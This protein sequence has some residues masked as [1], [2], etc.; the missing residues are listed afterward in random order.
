MQQ[1]SL[2][3]CGCQVNKSFDGHLIFTLSMIGHSKIGL[4]I[5]FKGLPVSCTVGL[6]SLE[7]HKLFSF[8]APL[9]NHREVHQ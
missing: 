2:I 8:F 6:Q 5:D 4:P 1:S 7:P 3:L 9:V